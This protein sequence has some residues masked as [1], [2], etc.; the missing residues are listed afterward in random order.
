MGNG[1]VTMKAGDILFVRGN[2]LVSKTIRLFDKGDF[3]HVA[4]AMSET[5]ILEA[6]YY[7]KTRITPIYFDNYEIVDVGLNGD[8]VLRF[9]VNLTGK[10]YDYLQILSFMLKHRRNNPNH[11][12]C[13]ELVATVLF[14][15]G[16]VEDYSE[17]RDLTPNELFDYL[18]LYSSAK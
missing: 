8:E 9:G 12:I 3:T 16:V 11:L 4:I 14:G 7:T 17:V 6:Q 15:L 1:R 18:R 10:W 13:S 5:H 2:S